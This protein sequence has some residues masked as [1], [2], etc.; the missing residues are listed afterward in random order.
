MK[1][2][3]Q[4]KLL[5]LPKKIT[6]SLTKQYVAWALYIYFAGNQPNSQN[7]NKIINA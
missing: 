3:N 4:R 5:T 6:S 2:K 1:K 7:T